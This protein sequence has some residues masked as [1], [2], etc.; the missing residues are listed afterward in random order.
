MKRFFNVNTILGLVLGLFLA[1]SLSVTSSEKK[2]TSAEK[3]SALFEK[4][5][6]RALSE[7]QRL[8]DQKIDSMPDVISCDKLEWMKSCDVINRQA[9]KN[10]SAPLRVMSKDGIEFNFVPGTSSETIRLQL[11]R[12]PEAAEA[13]INSM[14]KTMGAY[15]SVA[16]VYKEQLSVMGG[17]DNVRTIDQ[18]RLD[19]QIIPKVDYSL[20]SMSI[21]IES[22]CTAC[23][24]LL[25]NMDT[26]MNRHPKARVSVF[27]VNNDRAALKEKVLDKGYTGRTLKPSEVQKVLDKGSKGWHVMWIENSTQGSR[28][29]L[30]GVSTSKTIENRFVSISKLKTKK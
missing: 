9:K 17:M 8:E 27:M 26:F 5:L 22:N 6:S 29:I 25:A 2:Q 7:N 20:V 16:A 30:L 13:Y 11:E 12:T 4:S 15:K 14:G 10:P 28:D 19:D 18:M 24:A 1:T 21:F 23:D 3:M